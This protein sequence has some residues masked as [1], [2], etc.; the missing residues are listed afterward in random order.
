MSEELNIDE[1]IEIIDQNLEVLEWNISR[2][3]ALDRLLNGIPQKDDFHKVMIEGYLEIEAERVF[4]LLT[5]PLTVK[6]EDKANYLSQL[7]TIKN[8]S[9]YLGMD[10]YKGTVSM[11]ATNSKQDRDEL[12]RQKQELLAGKGE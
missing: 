11:V 10:S 2:A 7:D 4:G 6:P 3:E 9:R 5:H 1:Q 8:I 12:T